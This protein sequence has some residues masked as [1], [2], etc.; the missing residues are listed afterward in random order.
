MKTIEVLDLID[1]MS[2]PE[3]NKLITLEEGKAL[4][5]EEQ[6]A[7]ART[8]KQTT[9]EFSDPVWF[10]KASSALKLCRF[11]IH[12]MQRRRKQLKQQHSNGKTDLFAK[13][14]MVIAKRLLK[15]DVYNSL[16]EATK[17]ELEEAI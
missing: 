5:I 11:R 2:Y 6:L 16:I 13:Q 14:F 9:G 17:E 12:L 4:V 7:T 3:L 10:R 15:D 8:K 1:T